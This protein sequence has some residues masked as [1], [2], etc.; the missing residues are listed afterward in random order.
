MTKNY[1]GTIIEESLDD[2]RIINDLDV[3][4]VHITDDA[5]PRDRWH[6]YTIKASL[7]DIEKLS[8]NIKSGKWYMHFWLGTKIVAVFKDKSFEFDYNN[9]GSWQPAIEYG[10]SLDIP[11]EQLDFVIEK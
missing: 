11:R 6:L 8:H 5:N 3:T 2:N 4:K 10:L 9:K 1:T 7:E